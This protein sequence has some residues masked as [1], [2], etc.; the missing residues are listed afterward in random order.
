MRK[1]ESEMVKGYLWRG[2]GREK[3]RER[4][5][6]ERERRERERE[7]ERDGERILRG[8]EKRRGPEGGGVV[9]FYVK[10]Y[11]SHRSEQFF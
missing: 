7:R 10:K 4:E 11:F 5:R 8:N 3:E 1:R 6:R 9:H 2:R